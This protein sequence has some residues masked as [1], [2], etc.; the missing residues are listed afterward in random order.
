M[1]A[2]ELKQQSRI[3]GKGICEDS[4]SLSPYENAI[5]EASYK[6]ALDNASLMSNRG[7]LLEAARK[8]VYED[9][10]QYKKK[11]SRSKSFGIG[12]TPSTSVSKRPRYSSELRGKRILEVKE[13]LKQLTTR[14]QYAEKSQEKFANVQQYDTASSFCKEVSSLKKER[15]KLQNELSMLEKMDMKSQSYYKAKEKKT[16]APSSSKSDSTTHS[17]NDFLK[18]KEATEVPTE[19][20]F[21]NP[22][23]VNTEDHREMPSS[24]SFTF[25]GDDESSNF[26]C[27]NMDENQTNS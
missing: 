6:L 4:L 7:K 9:G 16:G 11:T 15:R 17:I 20:G 3:Y 23:M 19:G 5:N 8:K 24:D 13:D 27:L 10:Y 14:I 25:N 21:D 12:N 1:N 2:E 26:L 22:Q 18:A